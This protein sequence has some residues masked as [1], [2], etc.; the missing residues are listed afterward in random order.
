M[1]QVLFPGFRAT[2]A[3]GNVLAGAKLNVYE[4]GTTTPLDVYTDDA[5]SVAHAKPIVA[6]AGGL[7]AAIYAGP[8]D[9][10]FV[11]DTSADVEVWTIDKICTTSH[12]RRA[13]CLGYN[14]LYIYCSFACMHTRRSLKVD[15]SCF[16][17][18]SNL[19]LE[20]SYFLSS[21]FILLVLI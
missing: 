5:L 9:Y 16:P 6:D 14:Y 1:A 21:V 17:N 8:D 15:I 20:P 2:D 11:L 12:V 19:L 18:T 4:A 3:N 7:F 13:S 10:K